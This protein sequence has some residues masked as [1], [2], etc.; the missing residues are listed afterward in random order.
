VASY[1]TIA[2]E[3]LK[4]LLAMGA[5]GGARAA[6]GLS[7]SVLN[8]LTGGGMS[9]Q[10]AGFTAKTYPDDFVPGNYHNYNVHWIPGSP[11]MNAEGKTFAQLIDEA[12]VMQTLDEH[13]AAIRQFVRPGMSPREEREALRKGQEAEKALPKFW[14]ESSADV[15]KKRAQFSVSSSAVSGI[16]LTPDARIEVEWKGSPGKWYTFRSFPDTQKAS[17]EAQKLLKADS[18]GRAVMPEAIATKANKNNPGINCGWWNKDNY[19]P[20]F[21]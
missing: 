19:D 1:G 2:K 5:G 8:G 13:N 14:N 16:R 9:A 12:G 17:V 10:E 11:N 3:V 15:N 7:G 6:Y 4:A 21:A 20:T 18:I